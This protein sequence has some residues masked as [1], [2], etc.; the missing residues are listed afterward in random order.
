[1]CDF[2]QTDADYNELPGMMAIMAQRPGKQNKFHCPGL[3][4]PRQM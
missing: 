1:V 3:R 4:T 2:T